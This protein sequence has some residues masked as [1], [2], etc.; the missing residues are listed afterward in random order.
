MD[1]FKNPKQENLKV[2]LY[3]DPRKGYQLKQFATGQGE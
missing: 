3:R 1:K 2:G